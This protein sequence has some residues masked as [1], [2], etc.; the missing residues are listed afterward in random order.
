MKSTVSE[1]NIPVLI[2]CFNRPQYVERQL[3]ALRLVKPKHVYLASDGE[4]NDFDKI[5]VSEV[6][7]FYLKGI[8]WDCNVKTKFNESNLGCSQGPISAMQWFF[9]NEP[10]GIILEDDIIPSKDFFGFVKEMLQRYR[11]NKKVISISG[12]NFGYSGNENEYLFCNIMNM[13][14]WA[15]WKD[16]FDKVDFEMT[17][18]STKPNKIIFL[19]SRLRTAIFDFDLNWWLH[20][21]KIFDKSTS[22]P[23]EQ[24]TWWDY[25]LIYHQLQNKQLSVY[26]KRNLVRNLGFDEDATHTSQ[27]DNPIR[28][29]KTELMK[30]PLK[31]NLR[32]KTNK[33]FY[34]N[35]LKPKWANYVRPN[36]KY[37]LGKLLNIRNK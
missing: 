15:T 11:D 5:K 2:I 36:F 7:N 17:S 22:T 18:W 12:C 8:D 1:Y 4:R 28:L 9:R 23:T 25:Q 34:E 10:E 19:Y 24:L 13:W 35:Y 14:G 26:P 33:L 37:Y 32:F 30:F 6:R 20:W 27:F 16:R 31:V 21:K 3:E 29:V